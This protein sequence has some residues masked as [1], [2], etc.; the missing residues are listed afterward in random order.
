MAF[1]P[2]LKINAAELLDFYAN[3]SMESRRRR[4]FRWINWFSISGEFLQRFYHELNH[5]FDLRR[6]SFQHFK[7]FLQRLSGL[8]K[9]QNALCVQAAKNMQDNDIEGR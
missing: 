1:P 5:T 6:R 9:R 8:G 7:R 3:A 2:P 4:R